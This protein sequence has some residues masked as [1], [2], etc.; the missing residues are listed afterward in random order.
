MV[1]HIVAWKYRA[2]VPQEARDKHLAMLQALHNVVPGI[3]DFAVG[4]DFLR[5]HNSF[6]TGLFAR[7]RD[8]SVLEAYTVHPEHVKVVEYGRTIAETMSKVDF[9]E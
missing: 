1:T 2:D 9:E 6:D 4:F 8:R 7:F 3:E 5:A